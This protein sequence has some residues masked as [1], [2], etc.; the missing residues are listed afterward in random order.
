MESQPHGLA[1]GSPVALGGTGS[2]I[3]A[4]CP[5]T[6]GSS[7]ANFA[8]SITC[9]IPWRTLTPHIE[10]PKLKLQPQKLFANMNSISSRPLGICEDIWKFG[11]DVKAEILSG[12]FVRSEMSI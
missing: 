5:A 8:V 7:A 4:A 12:V 2:S 6:H 1:F 11:L 10:L 9:A 3:A